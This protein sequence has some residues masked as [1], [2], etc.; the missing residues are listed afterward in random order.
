[1]VHTQE[2]ERIQNALKKAG[3]DQGGEE[4]GDWNSDHQDTAD[5]GLGYTYP[6]KFSKEH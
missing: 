4:G 2:T 6:N 1:M 5:T 3:L